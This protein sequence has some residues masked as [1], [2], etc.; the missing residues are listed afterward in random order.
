M[1]YVLLG[2]YTISIMVQYVLIDDEKRLGFIEEYKTM[3]NTFYY[4]GIEVGRIICILY[5]RM[6]KWRIDGFIFLIGYCMMD[7]YIILW[8]LLQLCSLVC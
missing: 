1:V 2:L 6:M 8:Y 4:W 7:V 5:Y 3:K